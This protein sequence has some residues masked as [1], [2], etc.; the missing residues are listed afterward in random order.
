MLA[1]GRLARAR[2]GVDQLLAVSGRRVG[3]GGVAEREQGHGR[4]GGARYEVP[5]LSGWRPVRREQRTR[6]LQRLL[7]AEPVRRPRRSV[8][9]AGPAGVE[10]VADRGGDARRV[11]ERVT[12][13]AERGDARGVVIEAHG[14]LGQVQGDAGG[15]VVE[16]G[17]E[18]SADPARRGPSV[19][20]AERS[21]PVAAALVP[22]RGVGDLARDLCRGVQEG[23]RGHGRRRRRGRRDTR[24]RGRARRPR[25][26]A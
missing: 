1:A 16:V 19:V 14:G 26:A 4:P 23:L 7:G 5:S 22:D 21:H 2:R 17:A 18:R 8:G 11:V 20:A 3:Q 12:K 25:I 15:A 9:N 10:A 13:R 6:A 24:G